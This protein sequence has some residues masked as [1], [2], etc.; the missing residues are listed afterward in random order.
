MFRREVNNLFT[1]A[2]GLAMFTRHKFF[3]CSKHRI[4]LR[5]RLVASI[6]SHFTSIAVG[7]SFLAGGYY[8][9]QCSL[10]NKITVHFSAP[11]AFTQPSSGVKDGQ[12][13]KTFLRVK[14]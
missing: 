1:L 4:Q 2:M 3:L 8:S 7:T 14:D 12:Q 6:N 9:I 11:A 13:G 5:E 10:L